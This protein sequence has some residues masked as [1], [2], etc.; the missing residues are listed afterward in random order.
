MKTSV[1]LILFI[2][3]QLSLIT[4]FSS[5]NGFEKDIYNLNF[6]VTNGSIDVWVDQILGKISIYFQVVTNHSHTGKPFCR[7]IRW[8]IRFSALPV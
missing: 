4:C 3:I 2:A 8:Q 7:V 6:S 5:S 1:K